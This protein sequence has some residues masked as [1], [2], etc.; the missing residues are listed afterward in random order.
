MK[1]FN[2]EAAINGSPIVTRDGTPVKFVAYVPEASKYYRVVALLND[3]IWPYSE[4]GDWGNAGPDSRDL[5]M[6]TQKKTIY[7]NFYP[8]G[9]A[10]WHESL[11]DAEQGGTTSFGERVQW[12]GKPYVVEIEV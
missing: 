2:L 11:E 9:S 3:L 4:A 8:D 6:V 7:V 10:A 5:F 1:P 12:G